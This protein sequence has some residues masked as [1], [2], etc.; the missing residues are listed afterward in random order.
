[1]M[2]GL[3]ARYAV[4]HSSTEDG[5]DEAGASFNRMESS[6]GKGDEGRLTFYIRPEVGREVSDISSGQSGHSLDGTHSADSSS[7]LKP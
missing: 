5:H 6:G 3:L 7:N 2:P 4:D 1:M